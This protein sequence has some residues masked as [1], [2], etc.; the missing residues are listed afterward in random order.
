[1][2]FHGLKPVLLGACLLGAISC[3]DDD[4]VSNPLT[5]GAEELCGPCGDVTLGD[6]TIS[7]DA[8]ID[9][10]FKAIGTLGS[11]AASV[12]ADF[13]VRVRKLAEI[14]DVDIEGMSLPDAVSEVGA[15]IEAEIYAHVDGDLRVAYAPPECSA[16]L[17]VAVEAQAACEAKAGCEID[18][19]CGSGELSCQCDGQCSGG[20]SGACEGTCSMEVHGACEG[21]CKGACDL[22]V[23]PGICEGTCEGTCS[24]ACSLQD[25]E[26][27]CKGQCDGEC[28]G[29]CKPLSGGMECQGD[30]HGE[31]AVEGT[32]ECEGTCEGSCDAECTGGCQ[33]T[34]TP[35]SC[36]AFGSCVASADCQASASAQGSASLECSPPSLDI[37]FDYNASVDASART[38]FLAKM[39]AFEAQMVA[40]AQGTARLRALVDP[41]YAADL[42]IESP[43]VVIAGQIEGLIN[44]DFE[45]FDVAVGLIPCILP[46]LQDSIDIIIGLAT[47][48]VVV[49]E[50]QLSLLSIFV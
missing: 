24:G 21:S 9:G 19:D 22:S 42:G 25:S 10:F 48:S 36:S 8:R 43:V 47:D 15:A 29:S 17:S 35:P 32:A 4:D 6:S 20:C 44:A 16:N 7:G 50:G 28:S 3:G 49:L 46:A 34:A 41:N 18:G 26:G 45:D 37:D 14:F 12:R 1:M 39:E 2:R 13:E 33:G 30:C 40:I 38:E 5:D 11:A 31:C 27:N 23:N